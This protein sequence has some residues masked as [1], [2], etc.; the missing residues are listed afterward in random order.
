[1]RSQGLEVAQAGFVID[2]PDLGGRQ[3]LTAE[4]VKCAALM[5]FDGD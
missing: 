4:G 5:A 3:A 1:M 2:L